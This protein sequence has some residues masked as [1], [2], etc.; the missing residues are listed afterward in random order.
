MKNY[1]YRIFAFLCFVIPF[2]SCSNML[3]PSLAENKEIKEKVF[4]ATFS[5]NHYN[6]C[7]G[8]P[9]NPNYDEENKCNNVKLI[10]WHI[11]SDVV[12]DN[13]T[14]YYIIYEV[15]SVDSSY[16]SLVCLVEWDDDSRYELSL[17]GVE[18][19]LMEIMMYIDN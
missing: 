9:T 15:Q 4:N 7:W 14:G 5:D 11:A 13:Y 6:L 10:E 3:Q 16:Y 2:C 18:E 12:G 19:S 8:S 17:I 1:H